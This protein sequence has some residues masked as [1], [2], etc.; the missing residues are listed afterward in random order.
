RARCS[1]MAS[2]RPNEILL[3]AEIRSALET[4]VSYAREITSTSVFVVTDWR[5]PVE[6]Q[7][8]LRISFPTLVD[9]VDVEA[10]VAVHRPAQG[11][12]H[13]AGLEFQFESQVARDAVERLIEQLGPSR[14]SRAAEGRSY[15]VLLVEDNNFIR[16]MFAYG[17]GKFFAQRQGQVRFDHAEDAA[18][19]REKLE[20][21]QYDLVIVD[22]YLP[23]ED[24]AVFIARLRRDPRFAHAP[25]VA[26]S[27]GG[28]D[29]REATMSAGADLFLDKPVVLR[30][31]FK[32]L[33]VLSQRGSL[34]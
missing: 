11:V 2:D 10:R 23:S 18:S 29:A 9:P 17:I 24:G 13:P 15:S 33:Q 6:T 28:R 30:D 21:A 7:V 4:V 16:D 3:R 20:N 25:I 27:V 1:S 8:T 19:A 22:Y 14:P 5:P 26:I 12:G 34:A 32:T 31:L